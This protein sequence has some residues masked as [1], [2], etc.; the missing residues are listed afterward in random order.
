ME[1]NTNIFKDLQQLRVD[2]PKDFFSK[3]WKKIIKA[4]TSDSIGVTSFPEKTDHEISHPANFKGLQDFVPAEQ[5]IPAF[6]FKAIIQ[7]SS[8]KPADTTKTALVMRQKFNWRKIAAVFLIGS[9]IS[10]L[11][12]KGLTGINSNK[13]KS[14]EKPLSILQKKPIESTDTSHYK[15]NG[16]RTIKASDIDI[17]QTHV[18]HFT[19]NLSVKPEETDFVYILTSFNIEDAETFLN[20]IEKKPLIFLNKYSYVNVSE[21]MKE[22]LQKMYATQK[23]NK[24]TRKARRAKAALEKWKK[25]DEKFFDQPTGKNPFDIIDLSE[26]LIK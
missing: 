8:K 4:P 20:D 18:F 24:P 3:I 5:Q 25:T 1:D 22:F 19:K 16:S 14:G 7:Q 15:K 10:F 26:L 12:Y 6:D 21:K 13:N 2:P 9:V 23:K 17:T 11:L